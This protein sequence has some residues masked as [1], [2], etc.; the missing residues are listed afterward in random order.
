MKLT[1]DKL[2]ADD[3]I[4]KFSDFMRK[5]LQQS[6]SIT[7]TLEEELAYVENYLQLQKVRF[8]NAFTFEIKTPKQVNL[9]MLVPKHVVF[10]YVE[11]AVK[12]GLSH[13][14]NGLLTIN[15]KKKKKGTLLTIED[16]GGGINTK[17]Q[18]K[19]NSTGNG[20]LIMEKIYTYYT[21]L[22]KQK[23][24]HHLSEVTDSENKVTGLKIEIEI[25]K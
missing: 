14:K 19:R 13:K 9:K 5:T 2:A 4:C 1:D 16:N 18:N 10:T 23:I 12:H 20:L 7:N 22:T 11:N 3:F 25:S 8:N 24:K 15:I 21:Q 17:N 6:D